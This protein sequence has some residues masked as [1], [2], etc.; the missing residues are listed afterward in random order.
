MIDNLDIIIPFWNGNETIQVLLSSIPNG[1]K[2][3]LIKDFGSEEPLFSNDYVQ[4]V[5]LNKRGY[6]AG[7][8]N[9][10]MRESSKDV[11]VLNQDSLLFDGWQNVIE[12]NKS[13]FDMIGDGV[14]GNQ[15]W[16]KGYIQGTFM[17]ISRR[18]INS[19]G[20]LNEKLYPLWG[21]TCEYQLR[22]CRAGFSALPTRIQGY[23]HKHRKRGAYGTS[24]SLAITQEPNKK[25]VFIRTPPE[26]SVIVRCYN[27]G[28]LL[29]NFIEEL[30]R[31]TFQS[32]E[33]VIVDNGSIDNSWG[34]C[35]SLANEWQGVKSIRSSKNINI[36][37]I[38]RL[39]I[40]HTK[41]RYILP[42]DV[43]HTIQYNQI[44]SLYNNFHKHICDT[45]KM[46]IKPQLYNKQIL[47]STLS[48]YCQAL[49]AS[50]K[51]AN[52]SLLE[53]T[54]LI[55]YTGNNVGKETIR[56]P[57]TNELY[58]YCSNKPFAVFQEDGNKMLEMA[59]KKPKKR[60]RGRKRKAE[61]VPMFIRVK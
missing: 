31:Q 27:K 50:E 38:T 55:C 44:E 11:L 60:G 46:Y 53:N 15:A 61:T 20:F 18:G 24:I 33:V 28:S 41:G 52:L 10:G 19:V 23:K 21:C 47:K 1:Y 57:I 39:C 2:I 22:L 16:P 49:M 14:F 59:I 48:L 30:F 37:K 42:L 34:I 12:K 43:S 36:A 32:F 51:F 54:M 56:G 35:K 7:A 26:I 58:R 40:E 9:A 5:F 25:S 8:C 6:F 17:Y 29:Q 13:S 3:Y 4:V 45:S